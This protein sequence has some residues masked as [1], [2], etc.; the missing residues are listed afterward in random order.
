MGNIPSFS[1]FH[2]MSGGCFFWDF[3]HINSSTMDC[4]WDVSHPRPARRNFAMWQMNFPAELPDGQRNPVC[5]R[6]GSVCWG[7][8]HPR[9]GGLDGEILMI[10]IR[11]AAGF[12]KNGPFG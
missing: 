12:V 6:D 11:E 2:D 1:G 3:F 9:L 5:D 7:L 10:L 4:F 8:F